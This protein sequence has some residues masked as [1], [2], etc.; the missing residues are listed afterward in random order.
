MT[1]EFAK[2]LPIPFNLLI[3]VVGV[4][5]VVNYDGGIILVG[6]EASTSIGSILQ[7]LPIASAGTVRRLCS[8]IYW[9]A[10]DSR[11]REW[12]WQRR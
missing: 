1:S 3:A 4:E 6:P 9:N 11:T 5:D 8:T 2:G 7:Y 10:E 12:S